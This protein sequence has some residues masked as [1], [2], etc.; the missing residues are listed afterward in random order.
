MSS[1]QQQ[2][3]ISRP[4]PIEII[5]AQPVCRHVGALFSMQGP[6]AA[7]GAVANMPIAA[8]TASMSKQHRSSL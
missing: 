4:L 6:S 5:A 7:Q 2:H 1:Q 8:C 3:T